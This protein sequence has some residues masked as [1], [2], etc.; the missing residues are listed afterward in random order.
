MDA[1]IVTVATLAIAMPAALALDRWRFAGRDA[2]LALLTAPLLLPTIVLALALLIIFVGA[3][4]L[5][6]WAG[7][8]LA[9]MLV[10]W[11]RFTNVR[12]AIAA[13]I[14]RLREAGNGPIQAASTRLRIESL[15]NEVKA[16]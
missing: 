6:T 1:V 14:R 8:M 2:L 5:G 15:R 13:D 12:E 16:L 3:G 7:L 10:A 4:L 9:H 11:R